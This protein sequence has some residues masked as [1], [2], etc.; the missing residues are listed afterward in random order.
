MYVSSS[1][2]WVIRWTPLTQ[3]GTKEEE[4]VCRWEK[5]EPDFASAVFEGLQ[6]LE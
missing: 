1:A 3:K 5:K 4:K 2:D 6:H